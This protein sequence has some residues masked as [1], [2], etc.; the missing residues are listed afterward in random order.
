MNRIAML[1]SLAVA[2][3]AGCGPSTNKKYEPVMPPDSQSSN[4]GQ[5]GETEPAPRPGPQP[6]E[7][8]F[9]EEDFRA[10][11]PESGEPKEFSLPP[12]KQFRLKNGIEVYLVEQSD[13]PVVSASLSFE[14]GSASDPL[15]KEGLAAVCMQMLTEGTQSL[16]KIAYKEA[17]ADVASSVSSGAGAETKSVTM[18]TLSK[19]FDTTLAL[20]IDTLKNPAFRQEEFDRL[21]KRSLEALKEEKSSP[22]SLASRVSEVVL[23]GPKHPFGRVIT[24]DSLKLLAVDDCKQYHSQ[25]IKPGGARLF[26]VGNMTE[27]AVRQAFGNIEGW[28]GKAPRRAKLGAARAMPGKLFFVDVPGAAQSAVYVMHAGPPRTSP[29]YFAN[30]LMSQALGDSFSSRINMNLRENK[31]YTYGARGG[32][33]Y[34]RDHGTFVARTEVR[35]DATYQ[36]IKEL[37]REMNTMASGEA[38]INEAELKRDRSG[39]M[40]AM[41]GEFATSRAALGKY[42]ELVYFG[43]PLDYYNSFKDRLAK[44]TLAQVNRSAKRY[45]KPGE[46]AI[47]VVGDGSAP[48]I[49]RVD[50]KD[51]PFEQD[52][53]QLTLKQALEQ[54]VS[55]GELGKAKLIMLDADGRPLPSK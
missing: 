4:S 47:L 16:D 51:V 30:V 14:R 44:V 53:T 9:P 43:L 5:S 2:L 45:V 36:T 18:N 35:S 6:Q 7:L 15:G 37:L 26:I 24:D 11:Q 13:L 54:L 25:E 10:K 3:G 20:F 8:A 29:D 41:P 38:P 22:A 17:L 23:F 27:A 32:L 42:R 50:D 21:I 28:T 19:H 12:V 34:R 33:G 39:T 52:G 40:L 55:S 31:G 1:S 48:V 49:A 46:A